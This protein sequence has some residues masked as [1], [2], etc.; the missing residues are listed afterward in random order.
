M[1]KKTATTTTEA[2]IDTTTET[3]TKSN[4]KTNDYRYWA[5][6][7]DEQLSDVYLKD[8]SG[9]KELGDF[10]KTNPTC[11]LKE[12]KIIRGYSRAAVVSQTV[13]F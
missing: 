9:K 2:A 1:A 5:L 8:F 11:K 7:Y 12:E 4:K 3:T 10:L 6:I 13:R